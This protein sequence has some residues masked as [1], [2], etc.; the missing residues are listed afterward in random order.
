M[1]KALHSGNPLNKVEQ[2]GWLC[3]LLAISFLFNPFLAVSSSSLGTTVSHLPSFRATVASSELLLKFAPKEK[4]LEFVVSDC[5]VA[6]ESCFLTPLPDAF[7]QL[8]EV[9]GP[10]AALYSPVGFVWFRPPPVA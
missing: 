10:A 6:S 4:V 5:V 1:F 8:L 9:E 2:R 3:L 7:S